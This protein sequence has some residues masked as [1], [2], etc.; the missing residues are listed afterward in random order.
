MGTKPKFVT[1]LGL[2]IFFLC[3]I[4]LN[5]CSTY[6]WKFPIPG[7]QF[8]LLCLRTSSV[9]SALFSLFWCWENQRENFLSAPHTD[10]AASSVL[11]FIQPLC[12]TLYYLFS[13]KKNFFLVWTIFKA[14]IEFLTILLLFVMFAFFGLKARGILAFWP[15]IEPSLLALEGEVLTTGQPV[16]SQFI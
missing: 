13:L 2:M 4:A 15:G 11:C 8:T 16:K 10:Y 12:N 9:H 14:F 3:V 5:S 7:G 1:S 6:P